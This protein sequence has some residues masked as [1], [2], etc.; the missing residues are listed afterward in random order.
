MAAMP[1]SSTASPTHVLDNGMA[2]S[3]GCLPQTP[4]R[5]W[6]DGLKCHALSE[7]MRK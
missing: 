7:I 3:G 4:A 2:V 1:L 5:P 6:P